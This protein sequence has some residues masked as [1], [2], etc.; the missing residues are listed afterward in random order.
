MS[1]ARVFTRKTNA[2]PTD[3]L[4][5]VGFPPGER[6]KNTDLIEF[7]VPGIAAPGGSKNVYVNKETGKVSV[8]DACKRNKPWR[9]TV[10][11][12]A[13]PH[14]PKELL[15]GAVEL[16]VDFLMK[17]PKY[18]FG[19]G[20][21]SRK[22]KPSAPKYCIKKPDATKLLRALEDALTGVIWK[23]DAQVIKQVV[24]KHYGD[25]PG[26]FVRISEIV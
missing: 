18:H 10:V 5:F 23:D 26:A 3:E 12:H 25:R 14:R 2:T 6:E 22:L 17:R 8:V 24:R 13:W 9:N 1:I 19:T 21:N 4:A 16:R 11:Y 7:F 15:I 20:K